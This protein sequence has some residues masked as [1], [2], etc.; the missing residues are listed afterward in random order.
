MFSSEE[1]WDKYDVVSL[2]TCDDVMI[3]VGVP[4]GDEVMVFF[5]C[6]DVMS[7]KCLGLVVVLSGVDLITSDDVSNRDDDINFITGG[8][9]ISSNCCDECL[10]TIKAL[11]GWDMLV[12]EEA[13]AFVSLG[14]ITSIF[15][16]RSSSFEE[17]EEIF[18]DAGS[19]APDDVAV[20]TN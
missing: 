14:V 18:T 12:L 20:L 6:S 1:V 5:G 17:L 11:K 8:D 16:D 9:V 19:R 3:C 2:L 7:S 13:I 4:I 10:C 15:C